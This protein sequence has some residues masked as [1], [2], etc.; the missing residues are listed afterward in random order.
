MPLSKRSRRGTFWLLIICGI[1]ALLPR[2][3]T[4]WHAE[5][6]S[7]PVISHEA[8]AAI[9]EE[10]L[11]DEERREND[12]QYSNQKRF[13]V[14]AQR[15]DP[16]QYTK[17]DWM[18][19][20]LSVKQADVVLRFSKRGLYSNEDLKRIFVIPEELFLLIQ[21]STFYPERK[22]NTY[23]TQTYNR[24]KVWVDIN[25]ANKEELMEIPGIGAY[26]ADKI[27]YY[28]EKLGGYVTTEQLLEI[29]KFDNE[30]LQ[31]IASYI[32]IGADEPRKLNIRTADFE[33]LSAHPYIS[34]DVAN[35]IVKMRDQKAYQQVSDIQR[36]KLI[37]AELFEKLRP[38]LTIQ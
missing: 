35:S 26:F 34:Y 15:F 23:V 16:N 36:S 32:H 10:I 18:K 11:A 9:S 13:R 3:I 12:R 31:T 19:L 28:R 25:S 33:T 29:K 14:P 21:D 2:M 37:D 24:E 4:A 27:V 7:E 5:K 20:G 1:T 8:F 17:E 30:K 22:V 6:Y 38:Y